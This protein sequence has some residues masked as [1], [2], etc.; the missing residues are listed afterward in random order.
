MK[1]LLSFQRLSLDIYTKLQALRVED[2]TDDRMQFLKKLKDD[3]TGTEEENFFLEDELEDARNGKGYEEINMDED[4][5]AD[6]MAEMETLDKMQRQNQDA[7]RGY[8]L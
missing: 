6:G 8:F 7:E 4:G 2:V 3:C 5:R 1:K